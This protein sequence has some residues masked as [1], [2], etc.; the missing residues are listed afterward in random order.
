[1]PSKKPYVGIAKAGRKIASWPHLSAVLITI[2]LL[3]GG[4]LVFGSFWY[5]P[6]LDNYLTTTVT[7]ATES[8]TLSIS[9]DEPSS[10]VLPPGHFLFAEEIWPDGDCTELPAPVEFIPPEY[11]CATDERLRLVVQGTA[12]VTMEITP[13]GSWSIGVIGQDETFV[14]SLFDVHDAELYQTDSEVRY[15]TQLG[16]GKNAGTTSVRLRLAAATAM[17]GAHV[18]ESTGMEPG[19][20]PFW[21]PTLLAGNIESYSK[22]LPDHGKY[23]IAG[24]HLD[25]GDIV[26]V[27]PADDGVVPANRSIWGIAIVGERAVAVSDMTEIE[28]YVIHTVLH[29]SHRTLTVQRLGATEGHNITASDWSIMS[30][31]PNGQKTWVFFISITVVLAFALQLSDWIAD[32]AQQSKKN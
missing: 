26:Y 16:A 29:T 10:W 8:L 6:K 27:D 13:D 31:W 5:I 25:S 9:G 15:G 30:Q 4:S 12:T 2:V 1:M 28:Q 14:A 3:A 18:S 7:A 11:R 19:A 20:D 32:K 17:L 24:E 21:L 23:H 22:N